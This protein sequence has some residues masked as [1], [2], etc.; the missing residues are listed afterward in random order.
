M[1][2]RGKRTVVAA[3]VM[4]LSAATFAKQSDGEGSFFIGDWA[5][6]N[7]FRTRIEIRIEEI[8]ENGSVSGAAC[9]WDRS[10]VI[11]GQR[12][13][14]VGRL[15]SAGVSIKFEI[16]KGSFH[17]RRVGERKGEMWETRMRSDGTLTRPL[18]T[19][20]SRTTKPG[21]AQRYA[22]EALPLGPTT[23]REGVPVNG[24]WTGRW[25]DGTV[26]EL[27][28]TN[29]GTRNEVQGRY[30]TKGKTGEIAIYDL[31]RK[32]ALKARYEPSN[33]TVTFEQQLGRKQNNRFRFEPTGSDSGQLV[34][35]KRKKRTTLETRTM[36]MN[37]GVNPDGCL[38]QTHPSEGPAQ[39]LYR[40]MSV[41]A[42]TED[43]SK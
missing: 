13:D 42:A 36:R 20:L 26:A 19:R 9:W 24:N 6:K 28:V 27:R 3:T 37:R 39:E 11:F 10:G 33:S 16:G 21:C 31:D 12:L 17:I 30:C 8:E 7:R 34:V 43:R 15:S 1:E 38:V 32:G 25:E 2:N 23:E 35:N 40:N 14:E 22:R 5:G 4:L 18:R 41:G 29:A